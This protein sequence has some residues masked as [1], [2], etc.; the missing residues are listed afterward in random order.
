MCVLLASLSFVLCILGTA[1]TTVS[2]VVDDECVDHTFGM[3]IVG[4]LTFVP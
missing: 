3:Q 1:E 2:K 4:M